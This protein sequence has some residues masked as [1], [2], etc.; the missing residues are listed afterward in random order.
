MWH[1]AVRSRLYGG[2]LLGRHLATVKANRANPAE[3]AIPRFERKETLVAG[4]FKAD[5]FID[6]G[7]VELQ[8]GMGQLGLVDFGE[9]LRTFTGRQGLLAI[10]QDDDCYFLR[11]QVFGLPGCRSAVT[12]VIHITYSNTLLSA[13]PSV[14]PYRAASPTNGRSSRS[15]P[16]GPRRWRRVSLRSRRWRATQ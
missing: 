5:A 7:D 14:C 6:L 12:Y 15:H 11:A 3:A 9:E 10:V 13:C 8:L 1:G 16:C 2:V 4:M